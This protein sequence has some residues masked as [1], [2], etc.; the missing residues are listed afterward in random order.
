M[1]VIVCYY[2]KFCFTAQAAMMN[3]S[4]PLLRVTNGSRN[5]LLLFNYML[6]CFPY[7]FDGQ[8]QHRHEGTWKAKPKQTRELSELVLVLTSQQVTARLSPVFLGARFCTTP[9]EK[10]HV[11]RQLKRGEKKIDIENFF[12]IFLSEHHVDSIKQIKKNLSY[13]LSEISIFT[14]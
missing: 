14:K 7:N 12:S 10:F 5:S 4:I 13:T 1:S 8:K 6:T 3:Y 11:F 2:Y 9:E